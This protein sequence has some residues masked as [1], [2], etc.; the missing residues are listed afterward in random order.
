MGI[1]YGR[2]KTI[3]EKRD[4]VPTTEF[5]YSTLTDDKGLFAFDTVMQKNY[6]YTLQCP[7]PLALEL[8][9]ID[10]ADLD[11]LTSVILGQK[12]FAHNWQYLAADL[13]KDGKINTDDLSLMVKFLTG[14]I[15]NFGDQ[16]H[17]SLVVNDHTNAMKTEI[18]AEHPN[19]TA[20]DSV[21]ANVEGISFLQIQLGDI[22]PEKFAGIHSQEDIEANYRNVMA[23]K[24]LSHTIYPNPFQQ[25]FE[26]ELNMTQGGKVHFTLYDGMGKTVRQVVETMDAGNQLM[27]I[28]AADLPPSIYVYTIETPDGFYRGKLVKE[29]N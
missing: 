6:S 11:L 19:W 2:K 3:T 17:Y 5:T 29:N 7:A 24:E 16:S 25:S 9:N 28:D 1:F 21:K 18:M 20:F 22:N 15:E 4:T 13:N 14:E 26:V 27:T 12:S 23:H 10:K 8:Q